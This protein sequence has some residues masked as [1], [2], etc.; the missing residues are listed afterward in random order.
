MKNKITAIATVAILGVALFVFA[1]NLK[2]SSQASSGSDQA[3]SGAPAGQAQ[4][5]IISGL[6][7]KDVNGKT[8]NIEDYR[9]KVV[10]LD[11]WAT[12]CEACQIEIPWLI[13]FQNN[14]ES[15]G[16]VVIGVATDAEGA[17]K[18]APFLQ[19]TRYDVSGQQEPINYPIVLGSDAISDRFGV[20][21]L[22]T[23]ILISRDGHLVKTTVGL[24]S[25]DE[26]IKDIEGQF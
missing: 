7:F 19:K 13:E 1:R 17:S 21:A 22:P 15:R 26:I 8:V 16:F 11:F 4:G 23:G 14:Y 25:R 20:D 10:L 6:T 5:S 9:G 2:Q 24:V 18:V 3:Q 12:W